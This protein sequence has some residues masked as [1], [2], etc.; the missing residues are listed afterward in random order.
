MR[1]WKTALVGFGQIAAGYSDD[2][3]QRRFFRHPSHA[4]ALSAHPAF[5]WYAV[6][7]PSEAARQRARDAWGI[8]EVVA[9]ATL[10]SDPAAIDVAVLATA[11][12]ARLEALAALSGLRAVLV[13]KP[14][15]LTLD[16]AAQFLEHCRRRGLVVAVNM[17]RRYDAGC[18]ALA[19]GELASRIGRTTAVFGTYGNGL[20][21]NGTHLV[22]LIRMLLGP[23]ERPEVI[24]G[25]RPFR[26]GP[27][28]GD[29]NIAFSLSLAG[30]V[31]AALQPLPFAAYR[32]VSLDLWGER[33][34]LQLVHEGLTEITTGIGANRQLS[35]AHELV[36]D[37]AAIRQ[38]S[39]GDAFYRVYDNL[40]GV[41]GG[42][43]ALMCSG[44]EAFE[45]MRI[46]EAIAAAVTAP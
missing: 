25:S 12:D 32:E 6:V 26:E 30:G 41:L 29:V 42:G 1:R 15:G 20:R 39:I 44:D 21:N 38:T 40:A 7:D 16:Q 19:G 5:E 34:R 17:P 31:V 43:S 11:P 28:A 3:A 14:L 18:R 24:A 35:G 9:D 37:A 2:P 45:T 10:L 27:L 33:G 36:H 46:V 13:E 23:V 22:D 8:T 4:A